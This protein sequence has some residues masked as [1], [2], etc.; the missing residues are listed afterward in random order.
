MYIYVFNTIFESNALFMA[1]KFIYIYIYIYIYIFICI[2]IY[3]YTYKMTAD[4]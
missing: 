3:I 2:Y 4:R 1:L